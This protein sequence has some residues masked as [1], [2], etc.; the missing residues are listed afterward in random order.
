MQKDEEAASLLESVIANG[1]AS[2]W[3]LLAAFD[4]LEMRVFREELDEADVIVDLL[5]SHDQK[6]IARFIPLYRRDRLFLRF[7]RSG[8]GLGL[9][10]SSDDVWKKEMRLADRLSGLLN[11]PAH[12]IAWFKWRSARRLR[13]AGE[14]EKALKLISPFV[15]PKQRNPSWFVEYGWLLRQ[16]A[17]PEIAIQKLLQVSQ[18]DKGRFRYNNWVIL[19]ELAR[20][21]AQMGDWAAAEEKLDLYLVKLKSVN[22]AGSS[23]HFAVDAYLLKGF[24]VHRRGEI[25]AAREFWKKGTREGLTAEFGRKVSVE[26]GLT[27]MASNLIARAYA[28]TLTGNHVLEYLEQAAGKGGPQD[29]NMPRHLILAAVKDYRA[30][31]DKVGQVPLVQLQLGL[32]APDGIEFLERF[33]LRTHSYKEWMT[34]SFVFFATTALNVKMFLGFGD[35]D[36]RQFLRE[37]ALAFYTDWQ[38]GKMKTETVPFL[39]GAFKGQTGA[40]GFG[41]LAP[42]VSHEFRSSLAYTVGLEC[43]RRKKTDDARKMF[44]DALKFAPENSTT[45]LLAKKDLAQLDA[46][47]QSTTDTEDD[48]WNLD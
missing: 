32:M 41:S 11:L 14:P 42:L 30:Q 4:L 24:C 27:A 35:P 20:C 19:P 34:D 17:S 7:S 33:V 12:K 23:A 44:V 37:L 16:T 36:Q 48:D 45:R 8:M 26:G 47:K 10:M 46:K 21:H 43:L 29:P 6:K 1:I 5:S 39:Q 15:N 22:A 3:A 28:G 13:L 31:F 9:L 2:D 25:S 38:H 18:D 40:L